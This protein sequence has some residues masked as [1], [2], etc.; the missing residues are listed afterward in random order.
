MRYTVAECFD[1]HIS[2]REYEEV[3]FER[4]LD[5][6]LSE[7]EKRKQIWDFRIQSRSIYSYAITVL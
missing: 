7:A 5:P 2:K 6:G 3:L 1:G 4:N